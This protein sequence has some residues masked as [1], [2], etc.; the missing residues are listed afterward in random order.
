MDCPPCS[1]K[2]SLSLR[3]ARQPEAKLRGWR[4]SI[5]QACLA[6]L[7]AA[8]AHSE[9]L[10]SDQSC[11]FPVCLSVS[12][13]L[14]DF[15]LPFL[16]TVPLPLAFSLVLSTSTENMLWSGTV[17]DR[18]REFLVPRWVSPSDIR[19]QAPVLALWKEPEAMAQQWGV[20][21]K[22][23]NLAGDI[24][25]VSCSNRVVSDSWVELKFY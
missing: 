14:L 5:A 4:P 3:Q 23:R 24:L 2:I 6:G 25:G 13:S 1:L 17:P 18:G 9:H 20:A 11:C 12:L 7:P 19:R 8:S 16:P 15:L 10:S 21:L 22:T